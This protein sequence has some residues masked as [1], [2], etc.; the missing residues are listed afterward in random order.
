MSGFV[1]W[2]ENAGWGQVCFKGR[3]ER[4]VQVTKCK[5]KIVVYVIKTGKYS[6]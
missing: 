1:Y 5:G 4:H 6:S 2:S 3:S